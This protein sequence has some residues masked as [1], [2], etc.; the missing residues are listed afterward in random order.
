MDDRLLCWSRARKRKRVFHKLP[1][2]G[3][4]QLFDERVQT[5]PAADAKT[6]QSSELRHEA[7]DDT[8]RAR[9]R[10]DAEAAKLWRAQPTVVTFGVFAICGREIPEK[11]LGLD[12]RATNVQRF[13]ILQALSPPSVAKEKPR[14]DLGREL[15]Q[16]AQVEI[17]QGP[18]RHR[19][20]AHFDARQAVQD[21][22]N[23]CV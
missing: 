7:S 2:L 10:I 11:Y 16:L 19:R 13:E 23:A 4:G 12:P 22:T 3:L 15:G 5:P 14:D 18:R 9:W 6:V 8:C 1:A 21:A 20:V 17:Y